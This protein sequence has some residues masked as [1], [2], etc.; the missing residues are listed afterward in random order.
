MRVLIRRGG[1]HLLRGVKVSGWREEGCS[2]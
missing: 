2:E 1:M